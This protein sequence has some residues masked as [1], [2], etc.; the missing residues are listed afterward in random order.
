MFLESFLDELTKIA[1]SRKKSGE[2][3]RDL[4]RRAQAIR[5]K[6]IP[7][8]RREEKRLKALGFKN[9]EHLGSMSFGVNLPDEGT[10]DIDINVGVADPRK[11][12][13]ELA[14][15]GIPF[16]EIKQNS[17]IHRYVSPEG[18]EVEAKLRPAHEVDYM[19]RGAKSLQALS[20]KEK[21]KIVA[22]KHRLKKS[23]DKEAYKAYKWG[24]YEQHGIIPPGGAWSQ[25]Q[26]TKTKAKKRS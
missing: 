18:F 23:G 20:A 25:I 10:S 15:K 5:R 6:A 7:V 1:A 21:A 8:I 22:E 19:R 16:T 3:E 2:S 9:T 12:S 4:Y 11:A 26:P 14:A 13:A 17:W 24:I